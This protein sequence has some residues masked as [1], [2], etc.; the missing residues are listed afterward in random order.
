MKVTHH[1][2]TE[3][4]RIAEAT[5]V[6]GFARMAV[7]DVSGGDSDPTTYA[8]AYFIGPAPKPDPIKAVVVPTIHLNTVAPSDDPQPWEKPKYITVV[9]SGKRPD[10][11]AASVSYLTASVPEPQIS[12][13]H[14]TAEQLDE[15][16]AGSKIFI[17]LS[18]TGC[19]S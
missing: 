9:A 11:C 6:A 5:T 15:V 10:G 8:V 2:P 18:V 4:M 1:D 7:A 13:S 3:A 12:E 14:L 16:R 17:R 19:G